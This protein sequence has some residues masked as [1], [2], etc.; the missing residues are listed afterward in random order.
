MKGQSQ[1]NSHGV[2]QQRSQVG[3]LEGNV[4]IQAG[5]Q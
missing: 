3:S 1:S 2:E 5:R 4:N